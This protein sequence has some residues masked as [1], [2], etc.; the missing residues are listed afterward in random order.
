MAT[1]QNTNA[2]KELRTST[3]LNLVTGYPT[4]IANTIQ[5]VVN[6][7][8]NNYRLIETTKSSAVTATG[9]NTI[10]TTSATRDT[11][12]VGYVFACTKNALCDVASGTIILSAFVSGGNSISISRLPVLT[13]TAQDTTITHTFNNPIK[14]DRNTPVQMSG[15]YAAG[16]MVRMAVLYVYELEPQE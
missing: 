5:P 2:I 13:L 9:A 16:S 6:I 1:L 12:L 10:F 8:P 11:Y 14:I 7:N 4:Q 3:G 15:T